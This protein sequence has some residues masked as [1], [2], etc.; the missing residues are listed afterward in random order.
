MS[1]VFS[2]QEEL[3]P[4]EEV[5]R[6]IREG[7]SRASCENIHA[8]SCNQFCLNCVGRTWSNS[9]RTYAMAYL[10]PLLLK[11]RK[12]KHEYAW[13]KTVPCGSCPSWW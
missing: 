11:M 12:M 13:P 1:F 6:Y 5:Q 2:Q 7:F 3:M 10:V 9:Y 4:L 8:L